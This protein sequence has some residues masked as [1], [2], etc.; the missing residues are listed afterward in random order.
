MPPGL[1]ACHI[2][3]DELR[4][5]ILALTGAVITDDGTPVTDPGDLVEHQIPPITRGPEYVG[6]DSPSAGALS[7]QCHQAIFNESGVPSRDAWFLLNC[8]SAFSEDVIDLFT[9]EP[10]YCRVDPDGSVVTDPETTVFLVNSPA[11][12]TD[13]SNLVKREQKG[14]F[15]LYPQFTC[16]PYEVVVSLYHADGVTRVLNAQFGDAGRRGVEPR[17]IRQVDGDLRGSAE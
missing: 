5:D 14:D 1:I 11:L 16:H 3:S 6:P 4:E 12:S 17:E 9:A 2:F 7:A 10:T 15:Y 8:A 13:S